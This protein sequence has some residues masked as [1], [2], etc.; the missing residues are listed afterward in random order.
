M[1]TTSLL[2][3]STGAAPPTRANYEHSTRLLLALQPA[4]HLRFDGYA[5]EQTSGRVDP[6]LGDAPRF[7]HRPGVNALAV[8]RFEGR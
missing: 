5:D 8:E 6:A 1:L 7:A 4:P 3:R 2:L